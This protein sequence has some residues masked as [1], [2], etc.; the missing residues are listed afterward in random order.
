MSYTEFYSINKKGKVEFHS[1][2]KNSHLSAP[3]IWEK[4]SQKYF[5]KSHIFLDL[6]SY[7]VPFWKIAYNPEV[8]EY[9]RIAMLYTYDNVFFTKNQYNQLI[10]A[11][12]EFNEKELEK[13]EHCHLT[14]VIEILE[15]LINDENNYGFCLNQTSINS[16]PWIY[17]EYDEEYDEKEDTTITKEIRRPYNILK[18]TTIQHWSPSENWDVSTKEEYNKMMEKIQ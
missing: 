6:N 15:D 4:V 11:F 7:N 13:D 12:K 1:E 5:G 14:N 16:N 17:E 18:D 3:L 2:F 9:I 10:K 8:P